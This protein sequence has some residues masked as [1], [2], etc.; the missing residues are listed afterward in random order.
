MAKRREAGDHERQQAGTALPLCG[1]ALYEFQPRKRQ[2]SPHF[3]PD[4][5]KPDP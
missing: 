3:A 5:N 1:G 2:I 4:G